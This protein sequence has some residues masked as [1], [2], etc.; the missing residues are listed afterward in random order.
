MDIIDVSMTRF[1]WSKSK[2]YRE[3][4]KSYKIKIA[5]TQFTQIE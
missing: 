5:D 2:M 1:L 4:V 3:N